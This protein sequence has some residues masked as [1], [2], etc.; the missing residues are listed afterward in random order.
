MKTLRT[1]DEEANKKLHRYLIG[2]GV[3]FILLTS[4]QV[5]P[6]LIIRQ[7]ETVTITKV[8][9]ARECRSRRAYKIWPKYRSSIPRDSIEYC[10]LIMSDHG[11]F[12]LPETTWIGLFGATR[13][14]LFDRLVE[15]CRYRIVVTGPGLAL[16]EGRGTS[17]T[18]RTLQRLDPLDDCASKDN[19]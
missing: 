14:D 1:P 15:G 18:N 2:T 11:S 8:D 10:G 12:E 16:S 4:I 7:T 5:V 6:S 17:D 19:V 13:E 9:A 3:L